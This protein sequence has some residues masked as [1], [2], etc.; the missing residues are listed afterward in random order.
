MAFVQI[1][2]AGTDGV[3]GGK[4]TVGQ[5]SEQGGHGGLGRR[6]DWGMDFD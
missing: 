2:A 3:L 4:D 6:V 5:V 1:R